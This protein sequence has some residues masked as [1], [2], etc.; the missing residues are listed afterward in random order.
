MCEKARAVSHSLEEVVWAVNSRRDTVRDFTSYACK[1][2]Q[3][4]FNAS[5]VRCRLDVEP[6]IPVSK[7]ELPVRRGL[8][9]AVK[10]AL[11]NV[12][13]HS[14]AS[15]VH[16]RIHRETGS[17][18]VVVEDNGKGFAANSLSGDGNGI[19]NMK[20]RLR[21]IGG[22]VRWESRAG[23]GCRVEFRVPLAAGNLSRSARRTP[24]T[25]P[26]IALRPAASMASTA[27]ASSTHS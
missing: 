1:Y 8:F 11:N 23:N 24:P 14:G 17:L 9:L 7:L 10:E 6:E 25:E 22:S 15:E 12:A 3:T 20:E 19:E 4:F 21:D 5:P 16:L 26:G 2:A 27:S 18:V 13:R